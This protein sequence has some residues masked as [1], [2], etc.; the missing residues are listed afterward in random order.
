[1]AFATAMEQIQTY[2]Y[3]KYPSISEAMAGAKARI[4][5]S[6]SRCR[7]PASSMLPYHRIDRSMIA[8]R[9]ILIRPDDIAEIDSHKHGIHHC[10]GIV[11]EAMSFHLNNKHLVIPPGATEPGH[12]T[13]A[14]ESDYAG[15]IGRCPVHAQPEVRHR[16]VMLKVPRVQLLARVYVQQV[17]DFQTSINRDNRRKLPNVRALAA[18]SLITKVGEK[19]GVIK[20]GPGCFEPKMS[21]S[22]HCHPKLNSMQRIGNR[23]K[24][25]MK[26]SH[27]G[28]KIGPMPS[29]TGPF[30]LG[31]QLYFTPITIIPASTARKILNSVP[32]STYSVL[33][34]SFSLKRIID[35][36]A[37]NKP[38]AS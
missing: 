23:Q 31:S 20:Y 9:S 3:N 11:L 35:F 7:P 13:K 25:I 6:S 24:K 15:A 28:H 12:K 21:P 4:T 30:L 19:P 18:E 37:I 16:G 8:A 17:G 2:F 34:V 33:A 27:K 32:A 1:M 10:M 29:S 5:L 38:N 14:K 36:A 26:V 22:V